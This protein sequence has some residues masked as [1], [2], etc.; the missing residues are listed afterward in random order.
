MELKSF[1]GEQVSLFSIDSTINISSY[2]LKYNLNKSTINELYSCT[3]NESISKI[4]R[5][6]ISHGSIMVYQAFLE[7]NNK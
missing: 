7:N 5:L 4:I 6:T 1:K 2:G 3:L